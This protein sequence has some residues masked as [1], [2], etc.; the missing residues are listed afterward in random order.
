MP[1]KRNK[2]VK[3][4]AQGNPRHSLAISKNIDIFLRLEVAGD[5][6]FFTSHLV[7]LEESQVTQGN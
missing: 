7:G 5:A 3:E 1:G 6:I 2:R 4:E